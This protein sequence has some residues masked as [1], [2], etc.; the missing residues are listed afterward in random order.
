MMCN[1]LA[2]GPSGRTQAL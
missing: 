2:C 1:L